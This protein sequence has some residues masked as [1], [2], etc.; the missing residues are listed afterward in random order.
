M[1][2]SSIEK[3]REFYEQFNAEDRVL[4]LINADPDAIGSAL[5][6]K[7]LLWRRVKSITISHINIIKRPDNLALIRL[8]NIELTY[9]D[10]I[11]GAEFTKFVMVDS[12]PSHNP[13]FTPFSFNVII[14]HHPKTKD[15]AAFA[16]IRPRF[17]ATS[18]IMIGYIKAA[19]IKPSAR[20]ATA[21]F[22]GIKTDTNNFERQATLEDMRSFKYLF[23]YVNLNL[24][25]RIE[26]AEISIDFLKYYR[27]ALESVQFY[28]NYAYV[29]LQKVV[30][31]DVCVLIA[32]FLMKIHSIDWSIVS[33]IYKGNLDVILR[34]DGIQKDAGKAASEMFGK[35]GLAG[36][37]KS[38]AR[39]EIPLKNLEN[40]MDYHNPKEVISWLK[41][42][43]AINS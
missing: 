15:K 26:Y 21:L 29:H 6:V 10:K 43:I 38:M 42:R 41:K 3:L 18:T 14:D 9:I 39:A 16:D 5:A 1:K 12:Q 24:T 13:K 34:N 37:H 31:P 2:S 33:G 36:G 4:I 28:K 25:R 32:D 40:I 7:R 30:N 23:Q 20:L 22:Y 19:K 35:F 8:L 27:M 11:S 17:G